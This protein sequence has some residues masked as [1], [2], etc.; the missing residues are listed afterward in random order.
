MKHNYQKLNIWKSGI[1]LA[2]NVHEVTKGFPEDERFGLISQMRRAA[3][4]VP[5]SIAE[6]TFAS[7]EKQFRH[8]LNIALGSLAELHTHIVIAERI[9]CLDEEG[10][11]KMIDE[12]TSLKNGVY[13]FQ[14]KLKSENIPK[15]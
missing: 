5:S 13:G 2:V 6:G 7:T 9:K 3:Y 10:A 11:V 14:S 15:K 1:D 12:I 8:Y 4:G